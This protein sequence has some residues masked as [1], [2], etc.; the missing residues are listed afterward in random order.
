MSKI[1]IK[2]GDKVQVIAGAHK[3]SEGTVLKILVANNK[4]I[5]EGVNPPKNTTSLVHR[6]HKEGL[7]KKK[8]L[9][10]FQ[11]FHYLPL[12]GNPLVLVIEWKMELKFATLKNLM[13]SYKS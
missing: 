6:T 13:K 9:S 3:G 4:A 2:K 11:T 8:H 1:K 10:K 7:L 5:V 12:M